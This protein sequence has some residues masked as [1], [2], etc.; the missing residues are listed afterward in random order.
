M[1]DFQ[2]G[3]SDIDVCV[4]R[5][6]PETAEQ[7]RDLDALQQD[8]EARFL[9]RNADGWVSGQV[10]DAMYVRADRGDTRREDFA[11]TFDL[12]SLSACA[13]HLD[14]ESLTIP[15]PGRQD[16]ISRLRRFMDEAATVPADASPIW[17]AAM[18]QLLA[19]ALVFWRDDELV[20]KSEALE[21]VMA[22]GG[23]SAPAYALA[24]QVRR[25]G[26]AT[27]S[28]H[29][30]ALRSAYSVARRSALQRLATL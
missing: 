16:L 14:G 28:A 11:D 6:G 26:S 4:V 24:L 13:L 30:P 23:P 3:W 10:I 12:L 7:H 29:A 2:P 15:R 25:D 8:M 5:S 18:L 27:A 22:G 1:G 19:R 20:S 9:G 17:F 21:R